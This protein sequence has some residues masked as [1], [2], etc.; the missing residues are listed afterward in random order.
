VC[1]CVC[2]CGCVREDCRS[3]WLFSEF[4]FCHSV[5]HVMG[6]STGLAPDLKSGVAKAREAITSGKAKSVL[7]FYVR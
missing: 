1:V 3:Y 7:E 2:A 5:A 6:V 4:V